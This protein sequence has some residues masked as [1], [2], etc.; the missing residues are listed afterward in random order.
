M[1]KIIRLFAIISASFW[2]CDLIY[3]TLMVDI[4]IWMLV[5]YFIMFGMSVWLYEIKSKE[6]N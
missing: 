2:L 1:K 4:T 6:K 3:H 5:Y